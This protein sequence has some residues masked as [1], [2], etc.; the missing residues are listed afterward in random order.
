MVN[1][2]FVRGGGVARRGDFGA[3]LLL[4]GECLD[5][6]SS[7]SLRQSRPDGFGR[8][9]RFGVDARDRVDVGENWFSAK[10]E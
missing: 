4:D 2:D 10:S 9:G 3:G 6:G 8:G 7:A 5:D 1:S